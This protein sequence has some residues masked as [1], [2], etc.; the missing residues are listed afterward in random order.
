MELGRGRIIQML[1]GSDFD[2]L[3]ALEVSSGRPVGG[4]SGRPGVQ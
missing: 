3:G 4:Q 2:P 1:I